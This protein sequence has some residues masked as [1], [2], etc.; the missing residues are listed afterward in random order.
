MIK[1]P[2]C[3]FALAKTFHFMAADKGPHGLIE[4]GLAG[5]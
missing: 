2:A 4:K 5:P 1:G 3:H